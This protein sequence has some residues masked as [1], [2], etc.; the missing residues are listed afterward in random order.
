[1]RFIELLETNFEF[2]GSFDVENIHITECKNIV[3]NELFYVIKSKVN[4]VIFIADDIDDEYIHIPSYGDVLIVQKGG[5]NGYLK[6][7]GTNMEYFQNTFIFD[8]NFLYP[9]ILK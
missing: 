5:Q 2:N 4:N 8:Y 9:T 3:T 7:D 6:L 1:M